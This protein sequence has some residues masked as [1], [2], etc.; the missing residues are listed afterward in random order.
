MDR[1]RRLGF[2]ELVQLDIARNDFIDTCNTL[3]DDEILALKHAWNRFIAKD[4]HAPCNIPR[5][6]KSAMD[7]YAVIAK[8]TFNAQ[9]GNP[10]VL[11]VVNNQ[12]IGAPAIARF[13]QGECASIAT[14]AIIPE[15][16]TAVVKIENTK[17]V[18][19]R[20]ENTK[21]E[22]AIFLPVAP[23]AN[24][25]PEGEDF[26]KGDLC[27]AQGTRIIP[28]VTGVLATLGSSSVKV[29]RK[30][31]IS[32]IAT[33]NEL[34]PL[35]ESEKPD[36]KDSRGLEHLPVENV[37]NSNQHVIESIV[38]E[39]G[40]IVTNKAILPDNIEQIHE[41]LDSFS[42]TSDMVICTGGT[43][44][45]KG[46][47][48]PV[49]MRENFNVLHHGIAMRPGSATL[50]GTA[51]KTPILCLSG[52][53][54]AAEIGMIAFGMPAMRKMLGARVLDPRVKVPA[55][56]SHAIPVKHFGRRYM[57]RVKLSWDSG[58]SMP[59]ATPFPHQGSSVQRSML[60]SDGIVEIPENREGYE[61]GETV[62]V[63]LHPW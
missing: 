44:I 58:T 27:I 15:N 40:G 41:T 48:I 52:F 49:V 62:T 21:K 57:R 14:G 63:L 16:A 42:T 13:N 47:L 43:S 6:S 61:R 2:Q 4:I 28:R 35:T 9:P 20:K 7:G 18:K 19:S 32:I 26:K 11:N 39:I 1:L 33:G 25:I 8:D 54:V 17:L 3:D 12:P 45:G 38:E 37:I 24:I 36:E 51:N 30:P 29:K 10:A 34:I 59:I 5:V 31:R 60:E 22:V 50:L 53:P 23:G 55:F 46:D 56:L